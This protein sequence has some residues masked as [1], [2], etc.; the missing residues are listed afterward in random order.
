MKPSLFIGSSKE[1][2]DIAY[3]LQENLESVAEV[4]VW[5]Q[6]IFALS[7]PTISSLIKALD[8]SK[9]GAFILSPDDVTKIRG[10]EYQTAR[11]NIVFELGLFIGR[12]SLER[13]FFVIPGNS[14]DMHLPTD[15]LG[16]TPT[17]FDANRQDGNIR[18]ALGPA[19]NQI[20]KAL[21]NLESP[22]FDNELYEKFSKLLTNAK[23]TLISAIATSDKSNEFPNKNELYNENVYSLNNM[24]KAANINTPDLFILGI[25]AIGGLLYKPGKKAMSWEQKNIENE[26]IK[27][28]IMLKEWEKIL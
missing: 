20:R 23:E 8:K 15:L 17:V 14:M 11:D 26:I 6:G 24:A 22:R 27:L 9:F 2:L 5:D 18:A 25:D 21:L 10:S 12:L 28:E 16:L 4:T 3:A 19:S 1:S 7:Q 13:T